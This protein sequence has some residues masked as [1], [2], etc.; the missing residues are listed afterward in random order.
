MHLGY[1]LI[2][3]GLEV[4]R[5]DFGNF[6]GVTCLRGECVKLL[7]VPKSSEESNPFVV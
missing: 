4:L 5:A 3:A 1:D 2:V 7:A 6:Y